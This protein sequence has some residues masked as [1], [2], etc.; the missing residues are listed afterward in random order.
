MRKANRLMKNIVG[1]NHKSSSP[2]HCLNIRRASRAVTQFYEKLLEPSGLKVTQY[3]LLRNLK[4]MESVTIGELA[5]TM[6][7][8]RTTLS[9]N[10]KLLIDV[11]LIM[12]NSGEDPRSRQVMLTGAGKIALFNADALWGEAQANL[13]EYMGESELDILEKLLLKLEAMEP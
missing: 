4:H 2:C 5:K 7:I 1:C 11:D 6:R 13:K 10:M 3:S 12:V 9:R 8:N